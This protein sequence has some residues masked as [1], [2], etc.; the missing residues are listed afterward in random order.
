MGYQLD[1]NPKDTFRLSRFLSYIFIMKLTK[2]AEGIE[3]YLL[4][5]NPKNA[6]ALLSKFHIFAINNFGFSRYFELSR[7]HV[8]QRLSAV[9]SRKKEPQ[10]NAD[11]RR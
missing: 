2:E 3:E 8:N 1:R 11:G 5:S 9:N 7:I 6:F 4:E 10:M